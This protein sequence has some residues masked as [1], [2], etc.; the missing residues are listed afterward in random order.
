MKSLV[1]TIQGFQP[2]VFLGQ[3]VGKSVYRDSAI[4]FQLDRPLGDRRSRA[5]WTEEIVKE[6]DEPFEAATS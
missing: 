1:E 3:S 6:L 4:G 5:G 2:V